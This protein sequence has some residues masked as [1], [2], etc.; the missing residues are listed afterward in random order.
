M[1]KK[2]S[3][4]LALMCVLAVAGGVTA[5]GQK[6]DEPTQ[7]QEEQAPAAGTDQKSEEKA[8]ENTQVQASE[9]ETIKGEDVSSNIETKPE[10]EVE[11]KEAAK[12][13]SGK[14]TYEFDLS[15]YESEEPV[16][17]WVPY[18]PSI[19]YQKVSNTEITYDKN[20]A[21]TQV[22]QDD[23]GNYML[24]VEWD[25]DAKDRK[26]TYTFDVTREES[27]RPVF[28]DE[29]EMKND[30]E[31]EKFLQP[32]KLVPIDGKVKE[33]ADQITEGK[34]TVYDKTQAIYN[35][36]YENM[37]R[38]NDVIGCGLGDV[39][40]LLDSKM[41]KCTDIHSVFV[42]LC[43]A[44]G[45]P[46]R[47]VFGVRL[48]KDGKEADETKGQ[49]C[50]NEYYQPGTGWVS[51]DVA[52]VLKAVKNDELDKT[53]QE[54]LDLK[55]YYWGNLDQNRFAFANGRDLVLNPE[56]KDEPLNTFGYPYAEVN[57]KAINFYDPDTFSYKI[58]YQDMNK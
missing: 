33:L 48:G 13:N 28:K 58:T 17:L 2:H 18:V 9:M 34:T 54:A 10:A 44:S 55:D 27:Q 4:L 26:L 42:A 6:A 29:T 25:K 3:K 35:W 5:C 23:Y 45:I 12:I 43:R 7:T 8:A 31:L 46:S 36:I 47:E 39:N 57:G 56:Q 11:S 30:P 24:Y 16:R 52:D 38:D 15:A 32:S 22:N 51:I 14:V 20:H 40:A 1:I 53:S 19:D 21:K 41:G 49:H 50:W 37:E